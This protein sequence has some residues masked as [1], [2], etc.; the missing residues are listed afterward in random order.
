MGNLSWDSRPEAGVVRMQ[1]A[2]YDER[3]NNICIV[4]GENTPK[5]KG[6]KI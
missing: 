4:Q 2:P 5:G 6:Q 1:S 3:T